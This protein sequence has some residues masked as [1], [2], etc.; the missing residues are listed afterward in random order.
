MLW[1]GYPR[2]Y[3]PGRARAPKLVVMHYT[4]GNEGPTS[5]EA[6]A[7]YDKNR[8]D[9]VSC[10]AFFDS[11]GP[12]LQEV[13]FGDR[14]HSAFFKGNEIG[15]HY[16]LC[17]TRQTRAQWLDPVSTATL[18]TAAEAVRYTCDTLGIAKR[19]LSVA[20]VQ[21]AWDLGD[22]TGI[23]DHADITLAYGAG[24]HMDVGPEF[25]WDVF[26]GW[27]TGGPVEGD[28]MFK[29]Y[30]RVEGDPQ[31]WIGNLFIAVPIPTSQVQEM[32]WID[33]GFDPDAAAGPLPSVPAD[34]LPYVPGRL[35]FTPPH[36]TIYTVPASKADMYG[37]RQFPS[38]GGGGSQNLTVN[39]TGTATPA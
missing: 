26:M 6:G 7:Q 31:V 17:G 18:R 29:I 4:A 39:L 16:E 34:Q 11:Q 14:S 19:R 22:V 33:N 5:A 38:S 23:C 30:F 10:H 20:E 12:G 25:P 9:G 27:V 37:V 35:A 2:S 24:D 13:P 1:V 3:T 36:V 8:T 32:G 21:R 28:D 15:I